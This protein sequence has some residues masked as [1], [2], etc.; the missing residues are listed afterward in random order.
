MLA[1]VLVLAGCKL[2][3]QQTFAP[4]PEAKVAAP[5]PQANVR[6]PLLT[7]GYADKNPNYQDVLRYAVRAAEARDPHVQ[8]DVTATLPQGG[9]AAAA[10]GREVEVMRAIM[11]QGVPEDRIHL[12][13][14]SAAAA[15][16]QQVLVYVR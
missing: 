4:S 13:L 3:D 7:I 16:P 1:T 8:Y 10:Q 2:I 11:A 15:T 5:A 14:Q 6:T 12:G 9:D